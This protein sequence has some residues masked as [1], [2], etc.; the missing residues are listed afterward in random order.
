MPIPGDPAGYLRPADLPPGEEPLRVGI[1]LP[2]SHP[3][4]DIQSVSKGLLDAAQLAV[5]ESGNTSILLMPADTRGTAEGAAQAAALVL[6][7]GAEVVIGP[8]FAQTVGSAAPVVR[9]R[10]IPMLAFSTDRVAAGN[11]VYLLSFQPE[12]EVH[13]VISY[14]HQQGRTNFAALFPDTPYG[15]KVQAAFGQSVS[16]VGGTVAITAN[17]TSNQQVMLE[18]VKSVAAAHA[19]AVLLPEG[20]T[21]LKALGPLLPYYNVDPRNVKFMGTGLWDDPSIMG[22]PSVSGGWFAAPDPEG[23]RQFSERFKTAYGYAP[24]RIASLAY[25]AISL[26]NSYA[27][28]GPPFQRYTMTTFQDPNG[29]EGVDGIFRFRPDGTIERGLAVI[30]V[31]GEGFTVVS[32]SP[33]TF[34]DPGF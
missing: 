18:A 10:N 21:Q 25:D 29:F 3:S 9:A 20:G 11:G 34:Q 12:E 7:Q 14:A 8:L 13:R 6:S 33:K 5:F 28:A 30:E 4:A 26:I 17:Y 27:S 1:L 22:E 23:R 24:P 2:L 19:D 31:R 16:E 15:R 32:P